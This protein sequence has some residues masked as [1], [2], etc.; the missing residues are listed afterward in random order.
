MKKKLQSFFVNFGVEAAYRWA[1]LPMVKAAFFALLPFSR[2]ARERLAGALQ[3]RRRL[4]RLSPLGAG[5]YRVWVHAASLGEFECARPIVERLREREP[6][7]RIVLSF[8][9]PSGFR[10][11]YR[12]DIA[13]TVVYLPFDGVR[14]ARRFFDA[15]QPRFCVIARTDLW[16]CML[17]EAERRGAPVFLVS[18]TLRKD[19]VLMRSAFGR[20]FLRS[21][22]SL[23]RVIYTASR[24][25]YEKFVALAPR[26]RIVEGRDAR[27]DGIWRAALSA[28]NKVQAR[29][30]EFFFGGR[31][32]S[33]QPQSPTERPLIV[34][35]GSAHRRDE[36]C[37]VQALALLEH[38]IVQR[39][40]FIVV[41]HEPT[42]RTIARLRKRFPQSVLW[43][44]TAL[45]DT[46]L[47]DA[48][49]GK[50]KEG[51]AYLIV[52]GVGDLLS[53]YGVADA[54]FVGGGFGARGVHSLAEPAAYGLPLA[55]GERSAR[56][57][58]DAEALAQ[59]GALRLVRNAEDC[60]DWLAGLV[61]SA[62]K[63]LLSGEAARRYVQSGLGW[64][65]KIAEDIA[66]GSGEF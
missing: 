43:S 13:E 14:S 15:V 31:P 25:E 54:A 62:E 2:K 36:D 3:T 22:Y 57:S 52:D 41:P 30:R 38:R 42:A 10:R 1:A 29:A 28:G 60:A 16:R 40:R 53:L 56:R 47:S 55:C 4:A 49:S 6:R 21:T 24:A 45:S 23:C 11:L 5:E 26:S 48:V 32:Q 9:S 27:F 58:P 65:E 66:R 7:A 37:F 64:S 34:V 51:I 17:Q 63:R 20:E 46:V 39:L 61:E 18:A 12:S 19:G 44:D 59:T 33:S 8:F 50:V 35:L